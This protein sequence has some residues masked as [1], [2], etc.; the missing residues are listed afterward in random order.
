MTF[1]RNALQ[2]CIMISVHLDW[3]ESMY[4]KGCNVLSFISGMFSL[5]EITNADLDN[6]RND[7]DQEIGDQNEHSNEGDLLKGIDNCSDAAIIIV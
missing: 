1:I 7:S 6:I 5:T 3:G 4:W 2:K